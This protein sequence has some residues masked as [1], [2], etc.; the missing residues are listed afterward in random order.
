LLQGF[1]ASGLP[2]ANVNSFFVGF[3]RSFNFF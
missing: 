3:S 2:A 1:S